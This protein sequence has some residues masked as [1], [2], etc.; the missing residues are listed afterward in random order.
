MVPSKSQPREQRL[1]IL[2]AA[3]L[4]TMQ[5]PLPLPVSPPLLGRACTSETRIR[6]ASI[7]WQRPMQKNFAR[8]C[9]SV[10]LRPHIRSLRT[11]HGPSSPAR[12]RPA[13]FVVHPLTAMRQ[14]LPLCPS[15]H[16]ST[17]RTKPENRRALAADLRLPKP[18]LRPLFQEPTS[19]PTEATLHPA[20]PQASCSPDTPSRPASRSGRR[21]T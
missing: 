17:R 18:S 14:S 3:L 13:C 21:Q 11:F 7:F 6:V 5:T 4:S 10:R 19:S 8:S 20:H 16:H 9:T 1:R 12:H 15:A 2:A